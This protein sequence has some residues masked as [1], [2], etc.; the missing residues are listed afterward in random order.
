MT[1]FPKLLLIGMLLCWTGFTR[2]ARNG[3][4]PSLDMLANAELHRPTPKCNRTCTT[5]LKASATKATTPAPQKKAT[6]KKSRPHNG[7]RRNSLTAN[8]A[9]RGKMAGVF[10]RLASFSLLGRFD[11]PHAYVPTEYFPQRSQESEELESREGGARWLVQ[12]CV[13]RIWGVSSETEGGR[14][15]PSCIQSRHSDSPVDDTY[16]AAVHW[17]KCECLSQLH[18]IPVSRRIPGTLLYQGGGAQRLR[19]LPCCHKVL[20][21]WIFFS[22]NAGGSRGNVGVTGRLVIEV[23][24]ENSPLRTMIRQHR[25]LANGF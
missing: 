22:T 16:I 4:R 19:E 1:L 24:G 10:L 11:N 15:F 14:R 7:Q 21:T 12:G 3:H 6:D 17:L 25:G 18:R 8:S 13:N 2:R 23:N 5:R 20:Q 9:Q